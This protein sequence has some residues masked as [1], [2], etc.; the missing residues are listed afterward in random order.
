MTESAQ[1]EPP[2]KEAT[3][4]SINKAG[5]ELGVDRTT[6]YNYVKRL[7][8]EMHKFPLDRKAYITLKSLE[9]IK[10]AKQAASQG[11]R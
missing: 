4:I 3:F 7:Q 6:V 1:E 5:E 11:L 10:A 8:I 2:K 9:Q